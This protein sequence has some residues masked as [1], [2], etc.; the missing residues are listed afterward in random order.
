MQDK[1][2]VRR[3]RAVL[4][5]LIALSLGLLTIYFGESAGGGLHAI[6]RGAQAVL[7]PIESGASTA[8]KPVRDGTGWISDSLGAQGENDDLEAEVARL[9]QQ[10]AAGETAQR[11]ND[12][13]R[14]LV[15]LPKEDGFPTGTEPVTARVI[16]HSPTVWYSTLQVGTGSD[17][18]IEKDQPVVTGDGLVG[19]VADVT[20]GT[21]E[22]TLITDADS[23]VSAQLVPQGTRGIVQPKVGDPDDLL[24]DFLDREDDVKEGATVITSGSTANEFE[25]LFP[26]GIPIG[27]VS[28]VDPDERELYQRV[29]VRPFADIKQLD[30]VQI[31]TG[32]PA[33]GPA[34][35]AGVST[36]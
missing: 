22:V 33:A 36:P 16:A 35:A 17:D 19:K 4:A 12:Q 6:Q 18:G 15:D 13:L 5:V 23:A 9:R 34:E 2:V 11:E 28:R 8:T 10:V 21:A 31:L 27:K 3:R 32:D 7:G 29:H 26:R 25:S 14:A 30:V 1:N 20:G 24:L